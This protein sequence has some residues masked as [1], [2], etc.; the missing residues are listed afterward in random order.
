MEPLFGGGEM[1]REVFHDHSTWNDVPFRF[2][3]GTMQVAQQ[4]GLAEAVRYLQ[5]LGMDEVRAHEERP[6]RST[7]SSSCRPR[8]PRSTDRRTS[9]TAAAR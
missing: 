9:R 1:I 3:A 5:A 2:E 4:V 6:D 7:R 8:A